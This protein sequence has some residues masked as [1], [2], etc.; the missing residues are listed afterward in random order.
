[1]VYLNND[2]HADK[3]VDILRLLTQSQHD[4]SPQD[5]NLFWSYYRGPVESAEFMI[6]QGLNLFES[7]TSEGEDIFPPLATALEL[8]G[9]DQ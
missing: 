9:A 2:I 5:W 4:I 1:M 6:S 3:S 8:Y 7:D